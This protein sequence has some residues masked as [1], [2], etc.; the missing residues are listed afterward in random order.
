MMLFPPL[1]QD[2]E[3]RLVETLQ[4]VGL[5]EDLPRLVQRQSAQALH[6]VPVQDS[7]GPLGGGEALLSVHQQ[8]HVGRQPLLAPCVV[9]IRKELLFYNRE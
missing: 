5:P 9:C 3:P 2:G 6:V 8:G 1:T 4:E 7:S